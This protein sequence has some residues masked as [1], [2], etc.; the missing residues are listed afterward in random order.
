MNDNDFDA[1]IDKI[2]GEVFD[3]AK[4]ALGNRGFERWRNPKFCGRLEGA[5]GYAKLTGD[6]GDTM[7]MYLMIHDEKV[8]K[9][10]YFT[11][12]C[13]SSSIAGSFAA[14]LATGKEFTEVLDLRG[15][16]VLSKIGRFPEAEE[17]CAH[18]A[19]RT[20]QEALNSYLV[21]QTKVN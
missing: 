10:G 3:E 2:Q 19:I 6:C 14:E 21:K 16:D 1:L 20:L 13:S 11:D 18:L 7:E 17:H 8:A 9:V 15:T 5:D 4:E 12:G